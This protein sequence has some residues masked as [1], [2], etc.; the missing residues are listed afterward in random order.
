MGFDM[1]H[2]T[3]M[4]MT[5]LLAMCAATKPHTDLPEGLGRDGLRAA[6]DA[7]TLEDSSRREAAILR[8]LLQRCDEFDS[9]EPQRPQ[10]LLG[11]RRASR[12][13]TGAKRPSELDN[14]VQQH[15]PTALAGAVSY[16][17]SH[18]DRLLTACTQKLLGQSSALHLA[19]S[20]GKAKTCWQLLAAGS[21]IG[22]LN[23]ESA[24]AL[25]LACVAG[26]LATVKV[27]LDYGAAVD[28][29]T[30]RGESPLIL[31]AYNLH[32]DICI[33]L[34]ERGADPSL[35][36]RA[37]GFSVLH[38]VAAGVTRQVSMHFRGLS[39]EGDGAAAA[40]SGLC[41]E[42]AQLGMYSKANTYIVQEAVIDV[43]LPS[44]SPVNPDIYL[45]PKTLLERT[46]KAKEVLLV[47]MKHCD[48]GLYRQ[49]SR[50][51]LSPADLLLGMWDA[52]VSKRERILQISDLQLEGQTRDERKSNDGAWEFVLHQ[53][54]MI[55]DMVSPLSKK[56]G[57][58]EYVDT[59]RREELQQKN[60]ERLVT[61]APWLFPELI[62]RSAPSSRP[63]T[64]RKMPVP[65]G[66]K[67]EPSGAPGVQPKVAVVG[68]GIQFLPE[69]V[70]PVPLA[71]Q[72]QEPVPTMK[73]AVPPVVATDR[74]TP[75]LS[76]GSTSAMPAPKGPPK[77]GP[78]P[79]AMET[80]SAPKALAPAG[81]KSPPKAKM[82]PPP[83]GG[84]PAGK[85]PP[86]S[87][88]KAPTAQKGPPPAS[89]KPPPPGKGAPPKSEGPPGPRKAPPP[90]P[91]GVPPKPK[92]GPPP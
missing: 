54:F 80:P 87:G 63:A 79:Q 33:L 91:K 17:W 49:Q 75:A 12:T 3:A 61:E 7:A 60:K 4:G 66:P 56:T 67:I 53:I 64:Q 28:A 2:R 55:R 29:T 8:L 70:Q 86:P 45:F 82:P 68:T 47:M 65:R 38:A 81:Q 19:A 35:T 6:E 44:A 52:F 27:L 41:T 42:S 13:H 11:K 92:K 10:V 15:Q 25:H 23:S 24:T 48:D 72:A 40:L 88:G 32:K 39:W 59:P 76:R 90:A 43:R 26:D 31:A 71:S 20:R 62:L 34:L 85:I 5:A 89:T 30:L 18:R 69:A 21:L 74:E 51:G 37:E 9:Q 46:Q 57:R 83:K 16:V 58:S 1:F 22:A 78:P 14:G 84:P 73:E 50:R 36:T 77:Q